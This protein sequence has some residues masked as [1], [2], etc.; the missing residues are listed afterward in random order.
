MA[1]DILLVLECLDTQVCCDCIVGLDVEEV[2]D[3]ATL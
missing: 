1:V 3:G 2:L